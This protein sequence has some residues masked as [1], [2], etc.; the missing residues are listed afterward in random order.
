[1]WY[2]YFLLEV[3]STQ[4]IDDDECKVMDLSMT[5]ERFDEW[6]VGQGAKFLL[7]V[8]F[9]LSHKTIRFGAVYIFRPVSFGVAVS[10]ASDDAGLPV[11]SGGTTCPPIICSML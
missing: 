7:T 4:L 9:R 1:M 8:S 11:E 3:H 10:A 2:N 6:H 5:R